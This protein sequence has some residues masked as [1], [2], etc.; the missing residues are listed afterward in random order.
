MK[1]D[2]PSATA[3]LIAAGMILAFQDPRLS[4]S[5][6][7]EAHGW[8]ER[9]LSQSRRDRLLRLSVGTWF[10]ARLCKAVE[11][12]ALPG[13]VEH[14]VIRKSWIERRVRAALTGGCRQVVVL[15]AGLDTLGVRLASEK[16]PLHIVEIDHSAT[17]GLKRS[18][19]ARC[20]KPP[21]IFLIPCDLTTALPGWHE[22]VDRGAIDPTV[23]T[24]VIAEGLFMYFTESRVQDALRWIGTLPSPSL[25]LLF[26]FMSVEGGQH[27]QFQGQSHAVGRWLARQREPFQWGASMHQVTSMLVALGWDCEFVSDIADLETCRSAEY[28]MVRGEAIIEAIRT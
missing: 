9:F 11:R 28:P 22:L 12:I 17:Q 1:D 10:G 14:W 20:S 2:A 27:A 19:L 23:D 8:C 16:L 26:T 15:G 18:A 5:V 25:R 21:D 3:R 24:L 6:P 7:P 13:I 4:H